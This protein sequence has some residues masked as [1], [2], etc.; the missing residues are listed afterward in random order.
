MQIIKKITCSR[1][2]I[3]IAILFI[4][5]IISISTSVVVSYFFNKSQPLK[6]SFNAAKVYE[7]TILEDFS[8]GDLI[9]K[10]VKININSKSI[11][12]YVR[13]KVVISWKDDK[14]NILAI[15]PVAGTDYKISYNLGKWMFASDGFYYYS[16][17]L[18]GDSDIL[19]NECEVIS[20]SPVNGYKLNV[21]ILAQSVQSVPKDAVKELW[22]V[23]VNTDGTITK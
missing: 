9:K 7:P 1:R 18:L 5:V 2:N 8:D 14:N 23:N 19:I 22:G 10:N 3:T 12:S 17:P 6:N 16:E 20:K 21:E 15:E 11:A 4:F 13:A